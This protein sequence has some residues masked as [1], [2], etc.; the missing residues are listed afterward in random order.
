MK[1][2]FK[3]LSLAGI[4][5]ML[6]AQTATCAEKERQPNIIFI[7]ADD[8]GYGDLKCYNKNSD[9]V[10]PNIDKLAENGIRF[11]QMHS[12][13]NVCAPSR[14]AI[15]TGRYPSRLGEWAE[16]YQTTTDDDVINPKNEPCF[17]IY[18]KKAGYTNGMFGK[19]NIGSKEGVST[20]DA[21]GFDYWIGAHHNTSYFGHKKGGKLDFWE[22]GE[23]APQYSGIYAD[24][25]FFDK[26][27]EFIKK[28]RDTPFFIYL[29]LFTPHSPY[30][31]PANPA[32][33]PELDYMNKP[34]VKPI[35]PPAWAD[36]PVMKKMVEHIDN[37]I[38]DLVQTLKNLS[39]DENTLIVFTSD[40]GGTPAS[41]NYPL[42]GFKQGM[43]E[44]GIRVPS[45]VKW[46]AVYPAGQVSDQASISMDFS[47]T[48]IAAAG[49]DKYVPKKRE[50]DGINLSPILSGKKKEK[51]RALFWRRREWHSGAKKYNNVW[52]EAYIKG[53]WKYIK[54]FNEAPLFAKSVK[55]KQYP[56]P[57]IE[58]LFNQK[59]DVSEKHDLAIQN[60]EKLA[61]LRKEYER[62]RKKTVDRHKHYKIIIID[63]YGDG[64]FP[65]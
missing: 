65:K 10:T 6:F 37:R 61:E 14:R 16:A 24:D 48:I 27:I 42:S 11:T 3:L 8:L 28:N 35:G 59:E 50:L 30:Q 18:L 60:P 46:P 52:A 4:C 34:G 15:L 13:S 57:F 51:E 29:G 38:G 32:E 63:Q 43:L 47:K 7:L 55:E 20:P 2:Q 58:L 45:I 1:N 22:N 53:D 19:W 40:N 33:G 62:W 44:G 9:I 54:E 49:A 17:P 31:D 26:S 39:L 25:V 23:P 5:V 21:Q 64:E 36:H 12:A 41:V 56:E